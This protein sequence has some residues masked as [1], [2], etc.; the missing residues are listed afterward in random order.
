EDNKPKTDKKQTTTLSSGSE[1]GDHNTDDN[2]KQQ[3]S[4]KKTKNKRN[5]LSRKWSS[6]EDF[7]N[8]EEI[9]YTC[10]NES[11]FVFIE[12]EDKPM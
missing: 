9:S 7:T 10:N 5:S 2:E 1:S 4:N 12:D 8:E 3:R 11:Q 6:L